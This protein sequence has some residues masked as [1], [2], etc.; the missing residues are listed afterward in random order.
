MLLCGGFA[1]K[2]LS[3]AFLEVQKRTATLNGEK[4]LCYSFDSKAAKSMTQPSL[5]HSG[6]RKH[7]A[8]QAPVR[9]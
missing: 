7:K 6:R 5:F 3:L 8:K 9:P 2:T 1:A 4:G